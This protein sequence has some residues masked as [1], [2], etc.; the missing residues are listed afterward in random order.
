MVMLILRDREV[1]RFFLLIPPL[2]YGAGGG[3]DDGVG[4]AG[5][6]QQPHNQCLGFQTV[7]YKAGPVREWA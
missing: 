5:G 7:V 3:V 6:T 1:W 2:L 4:S